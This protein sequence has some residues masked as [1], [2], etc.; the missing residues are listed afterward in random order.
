[1]RHNLLRLT[2]GDFVGHQANELFALVVAIVVLGYS[3]QELLTMYL[4]SEEEI[5]EM[6]KNKDQQ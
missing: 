4:F 6:N 5:K 2:K 3:V 1:M